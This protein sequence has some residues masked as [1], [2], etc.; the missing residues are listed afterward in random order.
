MTYQPSNKENILFHIGLFFAMMIPIIFLAFIMMLGVI[1]HDIYNYK[2]NQICGVEIREQWTVNR[3]GVDQPLGNVSMEEARIL[4]GDQQIELRSIGVPF[5]Q[6]REEGDLIF[7]HTKEF[8]KGVSHKETV[9][10]KI[11]NYE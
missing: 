11:N 3:F 9:R 10:S 1:L 7:I 5:C 2:N 6:S 8:W 4:A